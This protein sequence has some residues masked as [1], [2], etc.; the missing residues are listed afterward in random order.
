MDQAVTPA[1]FPWMAG[2]AI[3]RTRVT[4]GRLAGRAATVRTPVTQQ[5][6]TGYKPVFLSPKTGN[7]GE[8]ALVA[9]TRVQSDSRGT[10]S[11]SP[12]PGKPAV[13]CVQ[14][15]ERGTRRSRDG[16]ARTTSTLRS[17]YA[18]PARARHAPALQQRSTD[19]DE[20][21]G[22]QPVPAPATRARCPQASS[23]TRIFDTIKTKLN[24]I[25]FDINLREESIKSN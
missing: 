11:M 5:A 10:P 20:V 21:R 25:D 13:P 15:R 17:Y 8:N 3:L 14:S 12:R 24:Y 16:Q 1:P 18:P 4:P 2:P 6:G 19:A 23:A 7:Y 22:G 9:V